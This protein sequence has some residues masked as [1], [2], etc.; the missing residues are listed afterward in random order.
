[1]D[2]KPRSKP[3]KSTPVFDE[4]TLPAGL[5]KAHST[6]AGVWGVIRVLEGEVRY[7]IEDTAE[8]IILSPSRP[9]LALPQQLHHVEPIGKVRMLVEFYYRLPEGF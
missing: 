4:Q 6:R 7:V 5:R 3:Y 8:Q 9:G 1:M 2:S